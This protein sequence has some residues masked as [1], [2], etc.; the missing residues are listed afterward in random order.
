MSVSPPLPA[1]PVVQSTTTTQT[2]DPGWLRAAR[3]AKWLAWA[4]LVWMTAEGLV[5]LVAG[6]S[7][8]SISVLT[9]AASSAVEGLASAIVSWRYTGRR[10]LSETSERRAQKWVSASFF[11]LAPYLL[12]EAVHRLLD[13]PRPARRVPHR[14]HR[15]EGGRGAVAR[16]ERLLQRR[17]LRPRCG[18]LA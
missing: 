2:P 7:A 6:L 17:L 3:R 14:R 12:Y 5:G 18:R 1:L 11:L 16:R 15:G 9:W 8:N 4:S 10:T 13:G